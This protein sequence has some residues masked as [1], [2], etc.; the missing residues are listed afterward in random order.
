MTTHYDSDFYGWSQ[1]QADLLRARNFNELDTE[2]LLEEIEAMGRSEQR[3]LESRLQMLFI[4]LLKWQYQSECQ[5]RSWKLTIEEQRRK[6]M[7]VLSNNPSLKNKLTLIIE[8]AYGDAV[9]GAERET[10]IKRAVFPKSCPWTFD[11][12]M[13][14]NFYPD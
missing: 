14:N 4:H 5:S 12:I 3:G 7:R 6:A 2:N 9:I 11:E 1:E 10:N 8:E 13:D